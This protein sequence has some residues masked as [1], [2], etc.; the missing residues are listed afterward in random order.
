M[1]TLKWRTQKRKVSDLLPL[2]YNPRKLTEERKK[3]LERSL[4]KFDLVEIPVVNTDQTI[5]AGNQRVMVLMDIG[6][7]DEMIDVRIPNRPLTEE[8]IKEYNITS[9][10]HVGIW[11]VDML[12]EVFSDF[13]LDDLCVDMREIDRL[14][15]E[16]QLNIE[17]EEDDADLAIPQNPQSSKGDLYE[18]INNNTGITHRILCGDSTNADDL[19]KL[20]NEK[21]VDLYL[22]D[23][24][25]NV[26]YE[27]Q[28]GMKIYNDKMSSDRFYRFLLN[29]FSL[30]NQYIKNGGCAYVAHADTEGI[31][32]RSAFCESGFMLKQCLIW[33]K[34]SAVMGRQDYNWQHEPILYGW[35]QG[36]AHYFIGDFTN[37]TL[38][39][40]PAGIAQMKKEELKELIEDLLLNYNNSIV[41]ANKPSRNDDH[42]TMKPVKLWAKLM[43]NSSRIKE[44]VF[45]GFMGS[46]TTLIAAEQTGRVCYGIEYSEAYTDIIIKRWLNLMKAKYPDSILVKLNGKELTPHQIKSLLK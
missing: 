45:D 36:A 41:R 11:D 38:L 26:D 7:G 43:I 22:T 40:K 32:F 4:V 39:E 19:A 23:P 29:A 35:K 34:N 33:A 46:G 13:D 2:D 15:R 27:G 31:N 12:D 18:L 21:V 16:D 44:I 42:P 20:M 17:V 14:R 10:T 8:E 24:P 25:Y 5:V 28:N 6:R 30:A 9:N 37:R 1:K 3:K